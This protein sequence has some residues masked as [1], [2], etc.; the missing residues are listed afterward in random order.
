MKNV[1]VPVLAAA[2]I[3]AAPAVALAS[4]PGAITRG[5]LPPT[6]HY[7]AQQCTSPDCHGA[8]TAG[9]P[10]PDAH[11]DY[12]CVD[13]HSVDSTDT[14]GTVPNDQGP[15]TMTGR[16]SDINFDPSLDSGHGEWN[17]DWN[18]CGD[19]GASAAS[20]ARGGASVKPTCDGGQDN[21][22]SGGVQAWVTIVTTDDAQHDVFIFDDSQSVETTSFLLNGASVDRATFFETVAGNNY[23]NDFADAIGAQPVYYNAD[24]VYFE[25][26]V[27]GEPYDYAASINLITGA[28]QPND[29]VGRIAGFRV[30]SRSPYAKVLVKGARGRT[31]VFE[32]HTTRTAYRVNS[33][34]V[35]RA[36]FVAKAR[37]FRRATT[38]VTWGYFKKHGVAMKWASQLSLKTTR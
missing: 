7:T 12:V 8:K 11:Y 35:S 38:H 14:S 25:R 28:P 21:Q 33:K 5:Q 34:R 18:N 6:A 37:R 30:R 27:D 19:R 9:T 17:Q 24:V 26:T 10:V 15:F 32:T 23:Y 20:G 36:A 16:V 13:C 22:G 29:F 31:Q 2:L 3:V 4:A 1:V